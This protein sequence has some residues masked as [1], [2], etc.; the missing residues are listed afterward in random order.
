MAE[1]W[2]NNQKRGRPTAAF[3]GSGVKGG[4][5]EADY[6]VVAERTWFVLTSA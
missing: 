5:G 1:R 6:L 3:G 2:R 4:D